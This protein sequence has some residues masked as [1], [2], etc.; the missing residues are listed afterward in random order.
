ML[1]KG[2]CRVA[3]I[4][5]KYGAYQNLTFLDDK[6]Q[7][8]YPLYKSMLLSKLSEKC[9]SYPKDKDPL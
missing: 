9:V 2:F 5:K 4:L 8:S 7:K 3:Q 6:R 1:A